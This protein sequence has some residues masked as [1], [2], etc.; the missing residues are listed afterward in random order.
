MVGLILVVY[1]LPY[2]IVVIYSNQVE[3]ISSKNK[4]VHV[5]SEFHIPDHKK[6]SRRSISELTSDERRLLSLHYIMHEFS[7]NGKLY[8]MVQPK[9]TFVPGVMGVDLYNDGGTLTPYFSATKAEWYK[10]YMLIQQIFLVTTLTAFLCIVG[11]EIL[12][13]PELP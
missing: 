1:T 6:F 7:A 12:L 3:V 9:I 5:I 4:Q 13:S 10:Y 8:T 2:I 11:P